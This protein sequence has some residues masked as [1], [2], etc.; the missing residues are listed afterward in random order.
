MA[1][2]IEEYLSKYY[3]YDVYEGTIQEDDDEDEFEEDS[4]PE[5]LVRQIKSGIFKVIIDEIEDHYVDQE[6]LNEI[7]EEKGVSRKNGIYK[8]V[9]IRRVLE[10]S[11][12]AIKI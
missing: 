4:T 6:T 5:V 10:E 7:L 11:D 9:C 1:E 12:V 8:K 2:Q 3:D